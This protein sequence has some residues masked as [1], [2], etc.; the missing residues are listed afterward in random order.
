MVLTR[1]RTQEQLY[2][3]PSLYYKRRQGETEEVDHYLVRFKSNV[4]AVE[5]IN[6]KDLFCSRGNMIKV[7]NNPTLEEI[8]TVEDKTNNSCT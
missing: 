2:T 7:N 5:L 8:K 6:S 4:I 1:M 3:K